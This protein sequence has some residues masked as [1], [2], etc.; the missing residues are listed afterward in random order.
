[1]AVTRTH[2]AFTFTPSGL[3][4]SVIV[5]TSL[6]PESG[7]EVETAKVTLGVVPLS[8][9]LRRSAPNCE[10]VAVEASSKVKT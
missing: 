9:G 6:N 2:R 7:P 4:L 3:A 5:P 10:M 8:A 1:L